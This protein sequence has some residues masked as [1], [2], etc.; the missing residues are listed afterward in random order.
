MWSCKLRRCKS[1]SG[2]RGRWSDA[3]APTLLPLAVVAHTACSKQG[4]AQGDSERTPREG[5]RDRC[6]GPVAHARD[7]SP[8][9]I[10][11][12]QAVSM[13][14]KFHLTF[15]FM[16]SFYLNKIIIILKKTIYVYFKGMFTRKAWLLRFLIC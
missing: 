2:K 16:S 3:G 13:F 9:S 1:E 5:T 12:L 10:S 15:N 7:V 14:G 6:T 4:I 8:R 11:P